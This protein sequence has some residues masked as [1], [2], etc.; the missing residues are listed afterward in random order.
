M[1]SLDEEVHR[2][3]TENMVSPQCLFPV[4]YFCANIKFLIILANAGMRTSP[5]NL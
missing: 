2:G 4:M 3:T 1:S 5:Y